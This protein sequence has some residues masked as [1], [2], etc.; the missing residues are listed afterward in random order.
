[1][2]LKLDFRNAFNC[3][4]RPAALN[5]ISEVSPGLARF[6]SWCYSRPS[7]LFFDTIV[8]TSATEVQQGDPMGPLMFSLA[9][10]PLVQRLAGLGRGGASGRALDLVIFYLDDGVLWFR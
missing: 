4:N 10:H 8:R 3:I 1:M 5:R 2:V 9:I 7:N 6:A